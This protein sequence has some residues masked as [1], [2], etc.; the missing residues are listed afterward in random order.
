MNQSQFV[1]SCAFPSL[2]LLIAMFHSQATG[3]EYLLFETENQKA[4]SVYGWDFFSGAY[5]EPH[6]SNLDDADAFLTVTPAGGLIS[7]TANLY[8]FFTVPTYTFTFCGLEN[9]EAFST[10]V[11]QIATT[12]IIDETRFDIPPSEFIELGELSSL[13]FDGDELPVYFYWVEWTG[14]PATSDFEV[15][16]E[17]MQM[18]ASFCGARAAHFNSSMIVDVSFGDTVLLGDV[19]CDGNVDLLDVSPFVELITSGTFS[20][21][22][23]MNQDGT[24]NLLDVEPFVTALTG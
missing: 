10:L 11:L 19:N 20:A 24:V 5:P 7:S 12:E 21:K 3:Q 23:D 9:S 18:H 6:E 14:L 15:A 8:A 13:P 17:G 2:I 22:A 1:C 16:V 4:N